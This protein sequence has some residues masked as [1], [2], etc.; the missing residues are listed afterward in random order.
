MSVLKV[1]IAPAPGV[2][3]ASNPGGF[4]VEAAYTRTVAG[5]Q[6]GT[7]TTTAAAE[8]VRAALDISLRAVLDLAD[9]APASAVELRFLAPSGAVRFTRSLST[10]DGA[11][12]DVAL[13]AEEVGL[14]LTGIPQPAPPAPTIDRRALFV[15]VGEAR[16]PFPA[17]RLQVAPIALDGGAWATFGLDQLFHVDAPR[18]TAVEWTV[19][20]PLALQ[21][22]PWTPVRLAVD[23]RF[24][25]AVEAGAGQAWMWWLTGPRS[26]L[27]VVLD[28]LSSARPALMAVALPPFAG[29]AVE[30]VPPGVPKDVT[31]G[32]VV[33]NPQIYTEDPGEF[34]KPFKNPERVLGERSFSV[35]LRAEQ[36]VIS[37][38]ATVV[39]DP[40]PVLTFDRVPSG[41][42]TIFSTSATGLSGLAGAA[43]TAAPAAASVLSRA[44]LVRHTLPGAY[45]DMLNRH[46]R[47]RTAMDAAHPVQWE[48]DSSRYQATTVARGHILEL[49]MRWRSNGYSLGTVAKTL[50]LAPRQTKRIQK[51]E[52][53]R[54][55]TARRTEVT[56]LTDRV[57]DSLTQ[58]R[59]YQDSVQANLSE[60]ARGSSSSSTVAGAGGFGFAT[61]GF[62]IG[63]GGGGS[64]AKSESSSEGGRQTTAS[65]EQRLRDAVRRYGDALRRL[66]ST[67]VTEVTQEETVTGTTEVV[68]NVNYGHALTVI[69][70]Q[71]LRHLKVETGVGGVRE[72]LFVPFA[73]T[74]FTLARAYRWREL[75]QR[76]LRD[77]R[78]A[79]AIKYL[80]DVLHDF[81][82]S[83]VPPRRRSEQD[84]RFVNGSLFIR[85]AVERPKDKDDGSYDAAAWASVHPFLGRPSLAVFTR[86]KA[87]AEAQREAVFQKEEAPAI[88]TRWV[89]TL[90][91]K[92]S[93]VPLQADFTLA[94]NYRFNGDV[95][96][97]FTVAAPP[98]LTREVLA[99]LQVKATSDLPPGSVANVHRITYTYQTDFFERAVNA[100]QGQKDLIQPET[101]AVD[102]A[103][104]EFFSAPD[105]WER[106]DVRAE[107]TNAV[108]NL[109]EHLNDHVEHYHKVIWWNLDR[110]RI[111]MLVDGFFAPGTDGLSVASVV[112]RDPIAIIGNS[113]VFRVASGSFLGIGDID[114][115]QKL[116]NY[117][118]DTQ[119]PSAPLLLSLP[120]DGLYAQTVM[121][122]CSALEEHFGN[123]DWV[124]NDPDPEL[125]TIAPEL[126]VTRRAE[127]AGTQP[128]TLPGTIINLQNA[129]G[130]P[131]PQGLAGV[132]GAVTNPNAF[133]DMA[134]LAGTQQNAAAGFQAAA[135]LASTFGQQAA[136]L[137]LA[138]S[139]DKAQATQTADKQLATVQKAKDKNLIP[140]EEAQKQAVK[141]LDQLHSPKMT[142]KPHKD[143]TLGEAVRAAMGLPGSSIEAT[144]AEG[145]LKVQLASNTTGG[146]GGT[147]PDVVGPFPELQFAFSRD[148]S[149]GSLNSA[150]AA[151]AADPQFKD[152]CA[153]VVDLTDNPNDPPYAGFNDEE[154]LYVGSLAKIYPLYV[155]FELR[156]RVRIQAKR[157][158]DAGT[159]SPARAGWEK[160]VIRRLE[161]EWQASLD[162]LLPPLPSTHVGKLPT[163]P[164]LAE[165]FTFSSTG[166]VDFKARSPVVTIA[167]ID[168]VKRDMAKLRARNFQYLDC[169]KS[170]M[171]WSNNEAAGRIIFPLSYPYL[172]GVLG[173]AG[174]FHSSVLGTTGLWMT[175]DYRNNDWPGGARLLSPRWAAAQAG[176]TRP[177]GK[178]DF[179]GSARAVAHLLTKLAK[180]GLVSPLT[181]PGVNQEMRDLMTGA[182]SLGGLGSRVE[183]SLIDAGRQPDLVLHKGGGGDDG[184][185]HDCAIVKRT[186]PSGK[187]IHY[188]VVGLGGAP[189]PGGEAR[190]LDM[191]VELDKAIEA[192][193]P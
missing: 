23:G 112:E 158:I 9:V 103:A 116:F 178:S 184:R 31:E 125:G 159:V 92:A 60:W 108:Y 15:P 193:H 69:Y 1:S 17:C 180:D 93:G 147:T 128:T 181:D 189:T 56:Q 171:R 102:S 81:A 190:L 176:P 167:E 7:P 79:D 95:R 39:A 71:I 11:A 14:V 12:L 156:D 150:M 78:Y 192:L 50:T 172:N 19:A 136:A 20:L 129:P 83:D 133:R 48:G 138:E 49:R 168:E 157:E 54:R 80:K 52:W 47:G 76:G 32:E 121:D 117:Y 66:E 67:V 99:K 85:L 58:E 33:G 134:G 42:P 164:Q 8:T 175:G 114:T 123:T 187:Q 84:V 154:I 40:L 169:L 173:A 27:G 29:G 124:L 132:L 37:A 100:A 177:G 182:R 118:A 68:R 152:M 10:S 5:S 106:Q 140:S 55:E 22:L 94:S 111:F 75:I 62:V 188:V 139:A 77:N 183:D 120:T 35:I 6:G 179:V 145:S 96:V 135:T 36:P 109:I 86:L 51:I 165:I 119:S 144:D 61:G 185:T 44:T 115:P 110:D 91:L 30:E 64:K 162:K 142:T 21:G 149:V 126:L 46:P 107:M 16:V 122:E 59:D 4:L 89:D 113:L 82:G 70:Y 87:L 104:A 53:E 155:A 18:T 160:T 98:G 137:K 34:C 73:I 170:A 26:A 38:Q 153:A 13:S 166:Q 57:A 63:G 174:F 2:Q 151:I 146:A 191:F 65:E 163:F 105:S 97:D 101:G 74:P 41:T 141:I 25:F 186:L 161:K 143:Q 130:M 72:C 88:A 43:V 127:P 28:D 131:A 148:T 45:L 3:V 24:T 90:E